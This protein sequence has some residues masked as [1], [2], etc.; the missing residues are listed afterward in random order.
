MICR[1]TARN[2]APSHA[3]R[4]ARGARHGAR[5]SEALEALSAARSTWLELSNPTQAAS[6]ELYIANLHLNIAEALE[7]EE[8]KTSYLEA[9]AL[10]QGG[11]ATLEG[12]GVLSGVAFGLVTLA[13]AQLALRRN[14]EA[15]DK[16]GSAP[17]PT[18]PRPPRCGTIRRTRRAPQPLP[19]GGV[20]P[21]RR[22]GAQGRKWLGERGQ[23][24]RILLDHLP[25]SE[26]YADSRRLSY[27]PPHALP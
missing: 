17:S 12:A 22:P 18:S 20:H 10:A 23:R 21:H 24:V 1:N 4:G 26:R 7:D 25:Y 19:L 5:N 3:G 14:G 9:A 2:S 13:E 6:V 8:A 16:R 27:S 15:K 11:V